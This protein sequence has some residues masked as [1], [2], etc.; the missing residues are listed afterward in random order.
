MNGQFVFS[1]AADFDRWISGNIYCNLK[2][3]VVLQNNELPQNAYVLH[4]GTI[5][6]LLLKDWH[7]VEKV[8][9]TETMADFV[10]ERFDRNE[11]EITISFRPLQN[12]LNT[13]LCS[14]L[15]CSHPKTPF[16]RFIKVRKT[17]YH[18]G[19]PAIQFLFRLFGTRSWSFKAIKIFWRY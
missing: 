4:T 11:T 17:C 12:V 6:P 9:Q 5:R 10:A 3:D 19:K 18:N 14:S 13:V 16:P 8:V 1:E 7:I 15:L 2:K